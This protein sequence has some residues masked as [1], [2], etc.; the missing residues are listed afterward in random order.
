MKQLRTIAAVAAIGAA[1]GVAGPALAAK[2][3]TVS[4]STTSGLKFTGMP[5]S[6]KAGTYTFKYTN[7]SGMGHNLKVGTVSTPTFT[8][9]TKSITVTLKKGTVKYLCTV[10][11][12]AAAGMKGSITVK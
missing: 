11:G 12:H 10:P 5:S 8:K 3:V 9:G 4:V 6:L 7:S 1:V 2:P